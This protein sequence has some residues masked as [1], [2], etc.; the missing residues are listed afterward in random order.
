[1]KKTLVKFFAGVTAAASLL[2]A[3]CTNQLDYL[4]QT[5]AR[6]AFNV[7]GLYVEGLDKA[8]NGSEVTL[9]VVT[10][11]EDG[12]KDTVDFVSG[13]VAD[14]YTK[15]D[16]T[17]V[18][19]QSGTAYAKVD[20]ADQL[21]DGDQMANWY[22]AANKD[23]DGYTPFTA[24]AFECYLQVG[25]DTFKV[26]SSD[27][28]S[29]EN[30]KLAVPTSAAKTADSALVSR[31]VK[32]N[33]SDGVATFSLSGSADEPVN[34]TLWCVSGVDLVST[35]NEAA[36][37]AGVTVDSATATTCTT[38]NV[39]K[40][41]IT[42]KGLEK[43]NGEKVV[44]AGARISKDPTA[45][46][47][48][49]SGD[50]GQ[51]WY[52]NNDI[53]NALDSAT[54]TDGKVSF[55]FYGRDVPSGWGRSYGTGHGPE[56]KIYAENGKEGTATGGSSGIC[57]LQRGTGADNNF[58]FPYYAIKTGST[59]NDVELTIDIAALASGKATSA[60]PTVAAATIKIDA[61]KV[62]NAPAFTKV[63]GGYLA[64]LSGWLSNFT[65]DNWNSTTPYKI[66]DV[67]FYD[68][69]N[70]AYLICSEEYLPG[71]ETFSLNMQVVNAPLNDTDS[72]WSHENSFWHGAI[73]NVSTPKL[74][75][76]DYSEKHYVLVIERKNTSATS[77]Y[78]AWLEPV[79]DDENYAAMLAYS[80]KDIMTDYFVQAWY[81]ESWSDCSVAKITKVSDHEWYWTATGAKDSYKFSVIKAN[82]DWSD[83]YEL[84][85]TFVWTV[86]TTVGPLNHNN[87]PTR[88]TIDIPE[89]KT[90]KFTI[91]NTNKGVLLT[92]TDITE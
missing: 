73:A 61:I 25:N 17:V 69:D 12:T 60:D 84:A 87:E 38:A 42:I 3:G 54:I 41:K 56:I 9:K 15:A 40:Y 8:Y 47:G 10:V 48:E 51:Y 14:S 16:G 77:A 7:A 83:R 66:S 89:G 92:T 33:V 55:E 78:Q 58:L 50:S 27:G 23:A 13:V 85:N 67:N 86:G 32:V 62:T 18:G 5:T 6:N 72:D 1:M 59:L 21:Y 91:R 63:T 68:D 53:S 2:L 39:A 44:L 26:A 57:L 70:N 81:T 34:V 29:L 71:T 88:A 28:T 19:Y 24:S 37:P 35:A 46:A 36:L 30:A 74:L 52:D 79:D 20:A 43:N 90:Y 76:N 45:I 80:Q 31:W 49:A 82:G 22:Y 4:D 64:F 65:D 11:D 75:T